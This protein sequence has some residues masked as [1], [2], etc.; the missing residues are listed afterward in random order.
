MRTAAALAGML[1]LAAPALAE[2]TRFEV[3]ED[4]PAFAG[5]SFGAAGSYRRI[6]GRATIA[7]DPADPRN[8]VIADLALAPRNPAGRVEA[9]ADVVI[10]RPADPA[11]GSGTML[12]D[13]RAHDPAYDDL[14]DSSIDVLVE[15]VHAQQAHFAFIAREREAGPPAVREAIA[16]SIELFERE[17]ASDLPPQGLAR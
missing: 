4:V 7:L 17:L 5:R 3:T 16:R 11:R 1:M 15:H 6:T 10:L 8:A 12:L 2:V 9:V 14:I 13:V